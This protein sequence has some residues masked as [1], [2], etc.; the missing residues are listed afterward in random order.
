MIYTYFADQGGWRF[1]VLFQKGRKWLHA[2]DTATFQVYR[3]PIAKLGHLVP[4]RAP[5]PK[6]M[7]KRL[8]SRRA[9][10][11]RL[12]QPFPGRAVKKAIDT[13]RSSV[14]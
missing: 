4:C 7:A 3:L 6:T 2:L 13:L 10:F 14:Q 11:K 12:H 1:V 5:R 8:A 9:T